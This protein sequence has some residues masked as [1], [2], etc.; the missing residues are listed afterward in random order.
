MSGVV[1][2]V[3]THRRPAEL[4][5]LLDCL[6]NSQV[7]LLGAVV[8]DHAPDGS[9]REMA[10][11]CLVLENSAN[12]GPGAGW[13]NGARAALE[14]WR[15]RV[16]ALWYLDDDVVVPPD[17]LGTLLDDMDRAGADAIAPLLE[18][19][20]GRLWAFPEP[21][22]ASQR[23]VIR[24]CLTPAA[25][26]DALGMAPLPCCWATG[27]CFLVGRAITEQVGFHRA[28]FRIL[29]EDLEYSMRIAGAGREV[30]TC[31]VV[32]PHLPPPATDPQAARQADWRKFS[33]LLQNLSYLSFHHPASRH[34]WTY[35]PGNFRRFFRTHGWNAQVL[36]AAVA[37]F[38]RG[39]VQG[40]P[41]GFGELR[42]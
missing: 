35:L 14:K 31:R 13:A 26:A 18:D 38:W 19:D 40:R 39:A 29:G 30:F 16:R 9:V 37:C 7:P 8:I 22:E 15:D 20:G 33:A 23:Q 36:R 6:K 5:R 28:D 21:V 4:R 11:G 10:K 42:R 25:A 34:M 17:A 2:V 32:I 3:V 27:A 1:A 41:A 24:T 12:P